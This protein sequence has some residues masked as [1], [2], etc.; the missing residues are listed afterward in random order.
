MQLTSIT[1]SGGLTFS[2]SGSPS[3][4]PSPGPAAT[5]GYSAAGYK[6]F[7][8]P[9][10][11]G[12]Y[13]L[14]AERFPFASDTNSSNIGSISPGDTQITA[15]MDSATHGYGVSGFYNYYYKFSFASSVTDYAV[16]SNLSSYPTW[17]GKYAA[18]VSS[19]PYGYGYMLGGSP[20]TPGPGQYGP[21][22]GINQIAKFPFSS[23]AAMSNVA[24]LGMQS[25]GLT[26]LESPTHGYGAGGYQ[27]NAYY[28]FP[29]A[30]ETSGSFVGDLA[31]PGGGVYWAQAQN[32]TTNGY[33]SGGY[34]TTPYA[35]RDNI[36]KFPFASDTNAVN[37]A[38]LTTPT[39]LAGGH[40]SGTH[41]YN[42]GG[43]SN[44]NPR[45]SPINAIQ[46][47]PF[48]SDT[49]AANVAT[50]VNGKFNGY[51]GQG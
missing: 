30:S 50:L 20:A 14:Y 9:P 8:D 13:V 45:F 42:S 1:I 17:V 33:I 4:S 3:P 15:S 38:V 32:S 19:I 34:L 43:A 18:G 48:S 11:P 31:V 51:N 22:G 24:A 2:S 41:G 27:H 49:N 16:S 36:L 25:Y 35:Y 6:N 40:S 37:V 46:K 29:F 7:N 26:G 39:Q 21:A 44:S 28:K 5:Y 23:T 10:A 47:F 12:T